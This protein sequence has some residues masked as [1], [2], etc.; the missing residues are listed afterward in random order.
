METKIKITR[1]TMKAFIT[2]NK[3][4]LFSLCKSDFDGMTDCVQQVKSAPKKVDSSLIDFE[5]KNTLGIES[6]WLVGSSRDYFSP[7]EDAMF[8][9]IKISNS[10]GSSVIA[11]IK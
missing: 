7:Y 4:N 6:I 5:K 2:K 10:C 8:K 11:V 1:A 9:G 3:E